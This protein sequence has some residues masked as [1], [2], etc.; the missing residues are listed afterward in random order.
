MKFHV[1]ESVAKVERKIATAGEHVV[2]VL[3]AVEEFSEFHK[4]NVIDIQLSVVV[5]GFSLVFLN[6]TPRTTW[7]AGELA[8]AL[9]IPR[10]DG[11]VDIEPYQVIE[12]R[13]WGADSIQI[14][15]AMLSDEQAR[16]LLDEAARWEMD[17]LVE[18]HDE[19]ELDRALDLDA[20]LIG[21]NNRNLK[22]FVTDMGTSTRL[23][24]KIP[25]DIHVVSESGISAPADLKRLAQ[26]KVT[27]VLVGE[28]LMRQKDVRAA[29]A[30]LL[31]NGFR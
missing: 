10:I 2:D 21:I 27:T 6:L 23:A 19:A 9:G 29:T 12:A 15:M 14:I 25:S 16:A 11:D 18:V 7:L 30:L 20:A 28:S 24:H 1:G 17:A 8:D 13:S 22:T 3:A 31:G 4:C 26:H 5:G